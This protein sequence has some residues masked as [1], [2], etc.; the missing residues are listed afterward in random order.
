MVWWCNVKSSQNTHK[1]HFDASMQSY[2]TLLLTFAECHLQQRIKHYNY[3]SSYC[4]PLSNSAFKYC[5]V[6]IIVCTC[7]H[8]YVQAHLGVPVQI[9]CESEYQTCI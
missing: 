5:T 3:K 2:H 8:V 6:P 9:I 4:F 7:T 1:N